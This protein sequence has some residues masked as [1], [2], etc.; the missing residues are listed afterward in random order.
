MAASG[1]DAIFAIPR[2]ETVALRRGFG[3]D[4]G[5]DRAEKLQQQCAGLQQSTVRVPWHCAA[6]G[7]HPSASVGK[8]PVNE[9]TSSVVN[10]FKTIRIRH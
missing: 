4:A 9:I 6:A 8:S 2:P 10:N 1:S 5:W 7:S 3:L